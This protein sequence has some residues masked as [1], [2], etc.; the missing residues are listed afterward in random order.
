[1]KT[2]EPRK[3]APGQAPVVVSSA[4]SIAW[5]FEQPVRAADSRQPARAQCFARPRDRRHAPRNRH[6]QAAA[7]GTTTRNPAPAPRRRVCPAGA[8]RVHLV[9]EHTAWPFAGRKGATRTYSRRT[10]TR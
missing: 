9:E 8:G 1:M 5:S 10:P 7:R 6:L 2:A 3:R 4:S